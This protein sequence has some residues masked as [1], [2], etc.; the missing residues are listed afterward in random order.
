DEKKDLFIVPEILNKMEAN[1]W[2]GDKTGQGFYK[3]T[4]DASGKTDILVLDLQTL[5]YKQQGRPKFATLE[6]T[7][8][9]DGLKDRFKVLL[10]GSDKAA[11][12]YRKTF[13]GLFEYVSK[14]IP[15]ISD[16]L[17]RI[18]DAMKTGFGWELGPFE[19]WDA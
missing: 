17:Y 4:K 6:A 8:T 9:I 7:K 11:D 3:K 18:D 14:R 1:K 12:F 10:S 16:E 5:E 19:T 13:L 2:L 15:E